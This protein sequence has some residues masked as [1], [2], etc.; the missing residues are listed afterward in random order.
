[1]GCFIVLLFIIFYV[2]V[3]LW[4]ASKFILSWIVSTNEYPFGNIVSVFILFISYSLLFFM[5]IIASISSFNL[6]S[7]LLKSN[8]S[9]T[10]F[11]STLFKA[12][13]GIVVS[14]NNI[15]SNLFFLFLHFLFKIIYIFN[16]F[17]Q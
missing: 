7:S 1:M 15:N 6:Y 12:Y 9:S 5:F 11:F 13:T 10:L 8:D 16:W 17:S 4:F 14:N 3:L 2:L